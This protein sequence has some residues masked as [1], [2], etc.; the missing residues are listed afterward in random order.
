MGADGVAD[1]ATGDTLTDS[2]DQDVLGSTPDATADGDP[3]GDGDAADVPTD[4]IDDPLAAAAGIV[5]D[6]ALEMPDEPEPMLEPEPMPEPEPEPVVD[7]FT[8]QI[9]AADA[10]EEQV[11]DMFDDLG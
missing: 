10:V 11:D 3:L 1:P 6:G 8:E 7:T 5:A 9:E 2:F 4:V